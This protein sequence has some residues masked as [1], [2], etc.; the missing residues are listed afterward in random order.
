MAEPEDIEESKIELESDLELDPIDD[1]ME[2]QAIEDIIVDQT[3]DD[4]LELRP[5]IL[6]G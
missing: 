5:L 1:P 6:R 3:G 4:T 2:A